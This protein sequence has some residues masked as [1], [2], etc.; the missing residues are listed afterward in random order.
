MNEPTTW[1]PDT[2]AKR[3]DETRTCRRRTTV[4]RAW[5]SEYGPRRSV[6]LLDCG[7]AVFRQYH[8]SVGQT[9]YCVAE[10]QADR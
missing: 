1:M 7:H 4:V 10:K 9:A 8:V 6:A 2:L 3:L 5:N